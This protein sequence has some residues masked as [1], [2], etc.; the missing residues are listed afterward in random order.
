MNTRENNI[1]NYDP[2]S[3]IEI[4]NIS[5]L[6]ITFI[7]KGADNTFANNLRRTL[8]SGVPTL[9]IDNII[10]KNNTSVINDE[11]LAKRISLLPLKYST[12]LEEIGK[13]ELFVKCPP[14]TDIMCVN[15]KEF[16]YSLN[17]DNVQLLYDDILL[18]KLKEGQHIEIEATCKKG[19][20]KEHCK[21]SPVSIVT[22][23]KDKDYFVFTV[24][25]IGN[26]DPELLVNSAI[27]ILCT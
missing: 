14:G 11:M 20:G 23:K 5:D 27:D 8:I 7:L 10:I 6:E 1:N 19:I 22:Y 13:F 3:N 16:K 26:I 17:S 25:C 12:D 2:K 24:E 4:V 21:F 15:S 9:A 18:C